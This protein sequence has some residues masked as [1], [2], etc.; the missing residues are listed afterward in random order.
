[1]EQNLN[2]K[3]LIITFVL[4][5]AVV[6]AYQ[7]FFA[8]T[9]PQRQEQAKSESAPVQERDRPQEPVD[10]A[11]PSALAPAQPSGTEAPVAEEQ[12]ALE[13]KSHGLLFTNVGAGLIRAEVRPAGD[14][15]ERKFQVDEKKKGSAPHPPE[16]APQGAT[17]APVGAITVTG[18]AAL[19][20]STHYRMA[21]TERTV[22]FTAE[23]S[24]LSV[25]KT[26]YLNPEGYELDLEVRVTN[27]SAAA[28]KLTMGLLYPSW[29][30]PTAASGGFSL[31]PTI[32][33]NLTQAI[34][35][36]G[37][38]STRLKV[39]KSNERELLGGPVQFIGLDG[40]YFLGALFPR[41]A[42]GTA[43]EL[44]TAPDG[45]ML[46]RID[47]ELGQVGPGQT[48]ARRAG[49]YLGPKS[50]TELNRVSSAAAL[51]AGL[52]PFGGPVT[53]T[54]ANAFG[55]DPEL[56]EAVDFGWMAFFARPLLAILKIFQ[57]VVVDWGLAIIL[58]TLLVKLI[59]FY[60]SKKQL[61]S[62]EGMR[63]LQ[64][65]MNEL[66]KKYADDKEKL[67][68]ERMRLFQ[69]HK[70][71]PLGGCL[72]LLIQMPVWIALYRTL[73]S[74]FELYREPCSFTWLTDLTAADPYYIL[75]IVM[76]ATMFITQKM[77]PQMG[78]PTQARFML[79]FMPIFFTVIM[80]NIPSG[81]TLYI[82]TNNLLSIAQ[83][84]YLQRQLARK[85]AAA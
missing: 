19:P 65:K 53:P 40:H 48:V 17:H 26:F 68:L 38:S 52:T 25:E 37:Q 15:P 11:E 23:T 58:L 66:A 57:R 72:P 20:L 10:K 56:G 8:P 2:L 41:S 82:F 81:L 44:T 36:A 42:E 22:T 14:W 35:R 47:F 6:T 55:A 54:A 16:L 61:E 83:Q 21:R 70:I 4:C 29:S 79:Y 73:Q 64:P 75:P 13:T 39:G 63:A 49:L 24:E 67:N 51:G 18:D 43:C 46:A 31:I 77:Q 78:D 59:L 62:M 71:N 32:P 33:Q 5:F 76:G 12:W 9:P 34:C 3:R 7:L 1:M 27:R 84:K 69:E 30:D 85:R 50:L 28:R 45:T 80:L 60:P 74:S